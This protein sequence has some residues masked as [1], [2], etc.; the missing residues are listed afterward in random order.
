[1]KIKRKSVNSGQRHEIVSEDD[2]APKAKKAAKEDK[3]KAGQHR[4]NGTNG[5]Q[6]QQQQQRQQDQERQSQQQQAT[7]N[8]PSISAPETVV[9]NRPTEPVLNRDQGTICSSVGIVTE[10]DSLGVCE[11]GT[12]VLL[13]GIVWQE[14]EGGIRSAGVLVVNVTW[15]GKTYV[16]TLLDAT[17]HDWAPPRLTEESDE[18]SRSLGFGG[19][20]K[21]TGQARSLSGSEDNSLS[22][23]RNGK[24]RRAFTPVPASP[25]KCASPVA[26][27]SPKVKKPMSEQQLAKDNG[28][29]ND[30]SNEDR[31]AGSTSSS[32]SS[33]SG[34]NVK[35][36]GNG[37]TGGSGAT[38]GVSSLS[39]ASA[40]G[41]GRVTR[42]M[43]EDEDA[44]E[45]ASMLKCP[46]PSCH[47]RFKQLNGLRYH[48]THA[49]NDRTP[50]P[51][52]QKEGGDD[53]AAVPSANSDQNDHSSSGD[54]AGVDK[55]DA[56]H[57]SDDS[58]VSKD[59]S[60]E[61]GGRMSAA[62]DRN[63]PNSAHTA[64][65]NGSNLNG[66]SADDTD[67]Q[68]V[69]SNATLDND[70][71]G[72]APS[73]AYSDISD[74]NSGAN[75]ANGSPSA[76]STATTSASTSTAT[77]ATASTTATT[78]Q[79][80]AT[81]VATTTTPS[82]T[83]TSSSATVT[84]MKPVV[85]AAA[86]TTNSTTPTITSAASPTTTTSS[87]SSTST[88][89]ATTKTAP[90]NGDHNRPSLSLGQTSLQQLPP[91][92]SQPQAL[93]AL[94]QH[95]Q[96]M[97]QL[98]QQQQQLSLQQHHQQQLSL[99]HQ[100]HL[101]MQQQQMVL[102]HQQQQQHQLNMQQHQMSSQHAGSDSRS[103]LSNSHQQNNNGRPSSTGNVHT[104]TGL[105]LTPQSS[106][107]TTPAGLSSD[108]RK[109]L[110][111]LGKMA[112]SIV[113]SSSLTPLGASLG[114]GSPVG[115][116][117]VGNHGQAVSMAK[118]ALS[119][120]SLFTSFPPGLKL[121]QGLPPQLGMPPQL[122]GMSHGQSPQP[123][124]RGKATPPSQERL[125]PKN[126]SSQSQPLGP[127]QF[128][129]QLGGESLSFSQSAHKR[130]SPSMDLRR[131]AG[132]PSPKPLGQGMPGPF[133]AP[134]PNMYLGPF[135]PPFQSPFGLDVMYHPSYLSERF[136]GVP[137][138]PG[139]PAA[140]AKATLDLLQQVSVAASQQT[141]TAGIGRSG[142]TSQSSSGPP[143]PKAG[144]SATS[145]S[146]S[147]GKTAARP[148][149]V[150]TPSSLGG[151]SSAATG[152]K[153][154]ESVSSLPHRHLHTHHHTHLGM[155]YPMY[156][157]YAA[158]AMMTTPVGIHPFVPK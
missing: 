111:S 136:G 131:D 79:T 35:S 41:L 137:G 62:C 123:S 102:Q 85:S 78:Q 16:G 56:K 76:G 148:G 152:G 52:A 132:G 23:L 53:Q 48:Q 143:K 117:L 128:M 125:T 133:G 114:L 135:A 93:Q 9:R 80:T 71:P 120:P 110:S 61:S 118:T 42:V 45:E 113:S 29:Q 104:S 7:Q 2:I 82:T 147:S 58:D 107:S 63:T 37:T 150:A 33:E 149:R 92:P 116:S 27:D 8:G 75:P 69:A 4:V 57:K 3:D 32:S 96:P 10:P 14:T 94:P 105:K 22:K 112:S 59:K 36:C 70:V 90:S 15:R 43:A 72:G 74:D 108:D 34:N 121:G 11:P 67:T 18:R 156:D 126:C 50:P 122:M 129:P 153:S 146:S 17:R 51:P 100:Q 1:M 65:S 12:S 26:A 109:D 68:N 6:Q 87:S 31:N 144:P 138:V 130:M 39:S 49:H 19:R 24:G 28:G 157:P 55:S 103:D 89:T 44:I 20:A 115:M 30:K 141:A 86:A 73:P 88:T 140:P 5:Q 95:L 47:K 83:T 64:E 142:S 101:S 99:Q 81:D 91:L 151:S 60:K 84:S 77:S 139:S 119:Q 38:S 127:N 40:V 54:A 98:H 134:P 145:P 13:E 46:E 158:A 97:Q 155:A 21:R 106:R 25:G 154:K 124:P 66:P